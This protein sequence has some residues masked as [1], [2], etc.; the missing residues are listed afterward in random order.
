MV[1]RKDAQIEKLKEEYELRN[2]LD[3]KAR[4]ILSALN[5]GEF[6]P[7]HA[8]ILYDNVEIKKDRLV[9]SIGD[10]SSEIEFFDGEL[11]FEHVRQ[12]FYLLDEQERFITGY[13]V[14]NN[15]PNR[16]V[17]IF[18]FIEPDDSGWK[19]TDIGMDR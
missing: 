19:I 7:D 15:T 9:F 11:D 10:Y 2:I 18:T 4:Q 12:R 6:S 3:I 1:E 17:L 14:F 8:E 16:A 5:K 13:E